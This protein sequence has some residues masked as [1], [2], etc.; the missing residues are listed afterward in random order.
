MKELED[1]KKQR[2]RELEGELNNIK[3][4]LEKHVQQA[5]EERLKAEQLL[6]EQVE[7]LRKLTD[8]E[9]VKREQLVM[10]LL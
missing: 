2:E 10:S 9:K 6:N 3:M 1:Q 5:E 8:E 4:S 7:E